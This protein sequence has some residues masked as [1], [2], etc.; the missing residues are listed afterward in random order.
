MLDSRR[1]RQRAVAFFSMNSMMAAAT[2]APVV[3][4][5]LSRPG[6]ELTSTTSRARRFAPSAPV[7]RLQPR[8]GAL[9]VVVVALAQSAVAPPTESPSLSLAS[10]VVE[11]Q[12]VTG[13]FGRLRLGSCPPSTP[14]STC[15][16]PTVALSRAAPLAWLHLLGNVTA[17]GL[18]DVLLLPGSYP[19]GR[20]EHRGPSAASRVAIPARPVLSS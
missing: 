10:R 4:S 15:S 16:R 17:G 2:S 6:E 20:C 1:S 8:P 9:L 3:L 18:G 19:E 5:M 14:M 13:A 11:G 7:G 12:P